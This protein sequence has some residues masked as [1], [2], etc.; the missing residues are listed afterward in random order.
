[1]NEINKTKAQMQAE[2]DV[3]RQRVVELETV[4]G[5][6][7][8]PIADRNR[9]RTYFEHANDLVFTLDKTGGI[10]FANRALCESS[11]YPLEDLL[12]KSILDLVT[13]KSLPTAKEALA[14]IWREE[15][16]DRIRLEVLTKSGDTRIV[17]VRGRILSDEGSHSES[18]FHIA[19]DVTEQVRTQEA[20]RRERDRA[21]R[22]LD[23]AG[24]IIVALN[25]QGEVTL[26]NQ[27]GCEILGFPKEEVLGKNWFHSFIPDGKEDETWKVFQSLQAGDI[28]GVEYVENPVLTASGGERIILWHNSLIVNRH[29][30]WVGTLSS[31]EDIT[32]RKQTQRALEESETKYRNL[33]ENANEA[34]VVAQD[35]FLKFVNPKAVEITGY[36]ADEMASMP[37][38]ELIHPDDRNMVVERYMKRLRGEAIP[39]TYSFR[40]VNHDG[41]VRWVEISAVLITWEGK[42]ATLNFL[43]DITEQIR[44]ERAL[45]ESEE[46]HRVT[47]ASISDAIFITNEEGAF[48]YI[49]PN[50]E[51][52]FGY[53]DQEV[54][55]FGTISRILGEPFF[56][57]DA[58][59]A[60]GEIPNVEIEVMNKWGKARTLLVTV[61][62][63]SIK[64]GRIL[65]TCRDI[66]ERKQAEE[67]LREY[68]EKLEEMVEERT[69]ELRQA[70]EQLTGK[71][72]LAVLGQLAGG[73]GHELRNPLG[74]IA[75]AVYFLKTVMPNPDDTVKE[76]LNIILA[77]VQDAQHTVS[78]LLDF[79]HPKSVEREQV[80][81]ADMS[82]HV[83]ERNPAPRNVV[84]E[85]EVAP[86]LPLAYVDPH[87]IKQVLTNLITN[88]YQAMP[89]GGYLSFVA[90]VHEI[91]K[92]EI[93]VRG[94][95]PAR[96]ISISIKDTGVGISLDHLD[97]LFEPLFT[98]KPGGIGLGLALSKMLVE[99]NGGRIEVKS[100]QG[101]GSNF[102]LYLPVSVDQ[103]LNG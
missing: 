73:V 59:E 40:I 19:R 48:T 17:E 44:T 23:I 75:N 78:D 15:G 56:S 54:E 85:T 43:S 53:S 84:V 94:L 10:T 3:L 97:K 76:Y 86:D 8:N 26:I 74:V 68:S 13:S 52:I 27:K 39:E 83:L 47:L 96:E 95:D 72:R 28:E 25:R 11:G 1:M 35:G 77:E 90:G 64:E 33:V 22:Y 102:T 82:A 6:N 12:G 30:D 18:T 63:V 100:V 93:R 55:E 45:Q 9:W 92:P 49:C 41:E 80:A 24:V 66:T 51:L 87:Q 71:Q 21:Q 32:E 81:I 4:V 65:Y 61:K 7:G 101:E 5:G 58:L 37:F 31:G 46:L 62:K 60:K 42:P 69:S 57:L 38:V 50:V 103:P 20:L 99:A 79:S 89:E 67:R 2:L 16:L 88:A 34:I 29:G 98:T 36:K 91:I 14:Q 70:Q